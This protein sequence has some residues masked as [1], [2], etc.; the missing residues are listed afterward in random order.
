MEIRFFFF[1]HSFYRKSG[2]IFLLLSLQGGVYCCRKYFVL[3]VFAGSLKLQKPPQTLI[4]AHT[5]RSHKILYTILA[6][7]LNANKPKTW[8]TSTGCSCKDL[9]SGSFRAPPSRAFRDVYLC[10]SD[11]NYYL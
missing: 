5:P 2:T 8:Q 9:C 6:Y 7:T 10:A 11:N 4:L 3:L 1:F